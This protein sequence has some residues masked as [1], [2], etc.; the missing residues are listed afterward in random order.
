MWFIPA[1]GG[2]KK[3]GSVPSVGQGSVE[4]DLAAHVL[5]KRMI[6]EH[7]ICKCVEAHPVLLT[8]SLYC[9]LLKKYVVTNILDLYEI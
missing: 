4:G 7:Q 6:N 3:V 2:F 5:V 9:I 8:S 1:F